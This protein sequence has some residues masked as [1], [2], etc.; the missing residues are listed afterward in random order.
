[1]I[2]KSFL[3]DYLVE[4]FLLYFDQPIASMGL[5]LKLKIESMRIFEI[6]RFG[7]S[8]GNYLNQE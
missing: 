7:E 6:R 2:E 3:F 1:M 5:G 8:A 4:Y